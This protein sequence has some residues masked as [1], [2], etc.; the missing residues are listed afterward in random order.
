MTDPLSE[1]EHQELQDLLGAYAL[2]AVDKETAE[3]IERHLDGCVKCAVEV[4]QHHEVAGLLANSGGPSP[5]SI[6]EGI[7]SRLGGTG[8]PSWDRLASRLEP[9]TGDRSEGQIAYDDP[10][11]GPAGRLPSDVVP[12]AE[13]R[14]RRRSARRAATI[15]TIAAA[16]AAVVAVVL[17]VQVD[18]LHHQ[19][20]SLQARSPLSAAEQSAL[21]DPSTKKVQLT[22][23][24]SSSGPPAATVTVVLTRSGT[25][26]VEAGGLS[27]LPSDQ[28]YQLWGVIG[29]RTISLGL[30]GSHPGVTPFSVAGSTAV[31]A[32]A[33]TAERAG[34]VEHSSHQPVVAGDVITA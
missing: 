8:A 1:A 18:H 21:A 27:S 7:E 22:A 28:T 6:W 34:G 16:A 15:A 24:P 29:D 25:G 17:G 12:M 26:F 13:A 14:S 11:A 3:R 31:S 5:A 9:G 10:S 19:V 2:D 23:A 4:S 33:I 30:L 32:F 20:S